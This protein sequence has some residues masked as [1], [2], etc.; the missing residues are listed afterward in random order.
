MT[1]SYPDHDSGAYQLAIRHRKDVQPQQVDLQLQDR[2]RCSGQ[3]RSNLRSGRTVQRRYKASCCNKIWITVEGKGRS[4][5]NCIAGFWQ[6][7]TRMLTCGRSLFVAGHYYYYV[8][9]HLLSL[10]ERVCCMTFVDPRIASTLICRVAQ[11][12]RFGT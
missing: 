2:I 3:W 9:M 8:T 10:R 4:D 1:I 11:S 6:R 7:H 12:D 5:M